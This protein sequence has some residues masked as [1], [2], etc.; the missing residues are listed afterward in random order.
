M[1]FPDLGLYMFSVADVIDELLYDMGFVW[2]LEEACT[3]KTGKR[4]MLED[5]CTQ[6]LEWKTR[7]F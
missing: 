5:E 2:I 4:G 1:H 6:A 3:E 7:D